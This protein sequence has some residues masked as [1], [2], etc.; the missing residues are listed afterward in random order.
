MRKRVQLRTI[1]EDNN[2]TTVWIQHLTARLTIEQLQLPHQ[3]QSK[4]LHDTLHNIKN[5]VK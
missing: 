1:T 3:L 2:T 4:I 5:E